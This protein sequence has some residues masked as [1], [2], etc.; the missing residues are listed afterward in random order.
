LM[1]DHGLDGHTIQVVV[2]LDADKFHISEFRCAACSNRL[3]FL[4]VRLI[5]SG[6]LLNF[7]IYCSL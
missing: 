6:N 1:C 4:L 7:G 5:V 2:H 3:P